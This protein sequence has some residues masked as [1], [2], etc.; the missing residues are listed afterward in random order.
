VTCRLDEREVAVN[1]IGA[2]GDRCRKIEATNIETLVYCQQQYIQSKKED[3]RK[4]CR[5][6]DAT[7]FDMDVRKAGRTSE[8]V[9][10]T[11]RPTRTGSQKVAE[12]LPRG[13]MNH[14]TFHPFY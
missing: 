5:V 14:P 2:G 3:K 11:T 7:H 4:R 1:K 13:I 9:C 12:V 10:G 6:W 8:C